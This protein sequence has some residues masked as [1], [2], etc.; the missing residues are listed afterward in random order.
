MRR[1]GIVVLALLGIIAGANSPSEAGAQSSPSR[2]RS[3]RRRAHAKKHG[4][5]GPRGS[6]GPR[7]LQGVPGPQ[8]Q[9]GTPGAT[10]PAGAP[11]ASGSVRADGFVDG[12]AIPVADGEAASTSYL[13]N[14]SVQPGLSGSPA[15]T[16]C[17]LLSSAPPAGTNLV[18]SPAELPPAALPPGSSEALLPYVTW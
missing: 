4:A 18:V 6:R 13:H 3:T 1:R 11:G 15:G 5:R 9:A 12:R 17:L 2:H 7:G 10:G 16:Y 8:G 14:V